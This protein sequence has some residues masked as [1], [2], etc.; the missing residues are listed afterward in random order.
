MP[1]AGKLRSAGQ[2]SVPKQFY[3]TAASR[4]GIV[5]REDTYL[6]DRDDS[7]ITTRET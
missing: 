7:I 1:G 6:R 2:P 4:K 5:S 3:G